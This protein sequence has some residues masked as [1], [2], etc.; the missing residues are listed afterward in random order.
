MPKETRKSGGGEEVFSVAEVA[1]LTGVSAAT[2]RRWQARGLFPGMDGGEWTPAQ[3]AQARTVARMRDRGHSVDELVEAV[4]SGRMVGYVDELATEQL[5]SDRYTLEEASELTGLDPSTIREAFAALGLPEAI[6]DNLNGDDVR[7]LS[8][9]ASSIE[10]GFPPAALLQAI[11][12]YG[13]SIARIADAEV[14]LLHLHVHEPLLREGAGAEEINEQIGSLASNVLPLSLP[15]MDYLHRRYLAHYLEQE[16]VTHL[17]ADEG[18]VTG[19]GRLVVAIAFADLAGYTQ[20]TEE[21]GD[22]E[23]AGVVE[24]FVER[25]RRSIPEQARIVK[26][27]G[28]EV[29]VVSSDPRPLA[30]WAVAFQRGQEERPLPRI[31]IHSGEVV[32]RDGDYF[33]REVNLAARV[34][35]RAAAGEVLVTWP[36]VEATGRGLDFDLIGEVRLKGFSH[37]TEL[38]LAREPSGRGTPGTAR[39]NPSSGKAAGAGP[40]GKEKKSRG[41]GRGK[42]K[43]KGK[44]RKA[45]K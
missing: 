44:G 28:D 31:G 18:G 38:F 19:E 34:V 33:G 20:L 3:I 27:I 37:A 45:K 42:G 36:V 16:I 9:L 43:R 21:L 6:V 25:V 11:R 13:Q 1:R 39:S 7:V 30:E 2:L 23:A 4:Q 24:R 40:K 26:T 12:V 8:Y 41:K 17:E 32:Y 10:S 5:L 15:T 14:R 22:E 35:A 29:M